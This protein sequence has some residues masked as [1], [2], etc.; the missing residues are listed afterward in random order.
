[1]KMGAPGPQ[2]NVLV[3]RVLFDA[4]LI[5]FGA[6]FDFPNARG[7]SRFNARF[8][9]STCIWTLNIEH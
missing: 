9:V 1:M 2:G 6:P 5:R 4:F 7:R 3:D 8:N